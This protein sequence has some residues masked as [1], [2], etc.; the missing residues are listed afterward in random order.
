MN[1]KLNVAKSWWDIAYWL[2]ESQG[3]HYWLFSQA[4]P[5]KR[6]SNS[7]DIAG[8]SFWRN[9]VSSLRSCRKPSW[10]DRV[11]VKLGKS[12]AKFGKLANPL[13]VQTWS[14]DIQSILTTPDNL[15]TRPFLGPAQSLHTLHEINDSCWRDVDLRSDE[16]LSLAIYPKSVWMLWGYQIDA[17][18]RNTYITSWALT[19]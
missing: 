5:V 14:K 3:K 13:G 17:I 18:L 10:S 15:T 12:T 6:R 11:N 16:W 7:S 8:I 1:W 2:S 4:S 9:A 19:S